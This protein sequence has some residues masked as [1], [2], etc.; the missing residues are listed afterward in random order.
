MVFQ[1]SKRDFTISGLINKN[2]LNA[3]VSI[4]NYV[5]KLNSLFPPII[6]N[7]I[8]TINN[9]SVSRNLAPVNC[10]VDDLQL[11]FDDDNIYGLLNNADFLLAGD[12]VDGLDHNSK[13]NSIT[14]RINIDNSGR[15]NFHQPNFNGTFFNNN[16]NNHHNYN[17][18][19][20]TS[21][22]NLNINGVDDYYFNDFQPHEEQYNYSSSSNESYI[23]PLDDELYKK[24]FFHSA[25]VDQSFG[26]SFTPQQHIQPP[27]LPQ[28]QQQQQQQS[29][30][31]FDDDLDEIKVKLEPMEFDLTSDLNSELSSSSGTRDFTSLESKKRKFKIDTKSTKKLKGDNSQFECNHCNAK[32]K[33]KGYLTRHLKKH[34]DYKAFQCPFYHENPD[35]NS[36]GTKCH[37]TGGFSRRDTFKT[38]LKALHFIYPP[39]TKSSGRNSTSGRCA[40]CFNFFNNNVEWLEGHILKNA[41]TGAVNGNTV[42]VVNNG[43]M[44]SS[45]DEDNESLI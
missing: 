12:Q 22:L 3:K 23:N 4:F 13:Y 25:S 19:T 11:S 20:N 29:H 18:I 26:P 28:A 32:F 9:N 10:A 27:T 17:D 36:K 38:H 43:P 39:G 2:L 5:F 42:N 21:H 41:C 8:L 24:D 31:K 16:N 45:N 37:P 7:N 33:V 30:Q 1:S 35:S 15:Q 34:L 44:Q 6:K 40:G 14:Q